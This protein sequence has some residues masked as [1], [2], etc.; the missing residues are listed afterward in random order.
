MVRFVHEKGER[1][2]YVDYES[3]WLEVKER[4]M[5]RVSSLIED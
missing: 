1:F 3:P 4:E 5:G 2:L